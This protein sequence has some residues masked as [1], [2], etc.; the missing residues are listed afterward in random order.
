MVIRRE[1]NLPHVGANHE[2][3][4]EQPPRHEAEDLEIADGFVKAIPKAPAPGL[5]LTEAL[6]SKDLVLAKT[7]IA[8]GARLNGEEKDMAGQELVKELADENA[9]FAKIL[10]AAGANPNCLDSSGA[11]ALHYA[12]DPEI[13]QALI[14]AGANL[15][16]KDQFGYTPLSQALMLKYSELAK[17]FLDNGASVTKENLETLLHPEQESL[18]DSLDDA[19][20][21]RIL[22]TPQDGNGNTLLHNRNL[23]QKL[24]ELVIA[25]G[26]DTSTWVNA[27]GFS[28]EDT[29]KDLSANWLTTPKSQGSA[30]PALTRI[31]YD[32][33]AQTLE[34]DLKS[35]WDKAIGETPADKLP[36][37][38]QVSGQNHSKD[39]IFGAINRI[40][41]KVKSQQAWLGTPRADQLD[42][43]HN[44]Y[45]E[46]LHN[47][48]TASQNLKNK[49]ANEVIGH[50]VSIALPEI[51]GRCATAYQQEFKQQAGFLS[52]SPEALSTDGQVKAAANSAL[53]SLV[54]KITSEQHGSDVHFLAGYQLAAGLSSIPD[55]LSH[56]NPETAG[57]NLRASFDPISFTKDFSNHVSRETATD[58]LKEQTPAEALPEYLE[59]KKAVAVKENNLDENTKAQLAENGMDGEKTFELLTSRILRAAKLADAAAGEPITSQNIAKSMLQK[60]FG[61]AFAKEIPTEILAL[62]SEKEFSQFRDALK[63]FVQSRI[64]LLSSPQK[65]SLRSWISSPQPLFDRLRAA[66]TFNAEATKLNFSPEQKTKF[67]SLQKEYEHSMQKFADDLD[68]QAEEE[69]KESDVSYQ[70]SAGSVSN[71]IEDARLLKY[72]EDVLQKPTQALMIAVLKKFGALGVPA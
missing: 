14:A 54:E 59:L 39:D 56:I 27:E 42:I 20:L 9:E 58:W 63:E 2:A 38:L 45:N 24:K 28:P 71:A 35:L 70:T 50:L 5:A 60:T 68:A 3:A 6:K 62:F 43:M 64:D 47:L 10:I 30:A 4:P 1:G 61:V 48:N 65:I 13:A 36:V 66:L 7:L 52:G 8:A 12:E 25:R 32:A 41:T 33:Q 72:N 40:L 69:G 18:L 55:P 46:M 23:D 57:Q 53:L 26:I 51:E 22:K 31:E 29:Q 19:T 16:L 44:F 67:L 49:P 17:L 11:V 34:T 15:E 37:L 21:E